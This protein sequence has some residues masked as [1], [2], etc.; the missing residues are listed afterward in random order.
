MRNLLM[1]GPVK[2]F[3]DKTNA[4]F[5]I[6]RRGAGLRPDVSGFTGRMFRDSVAGYR[7]IAVPV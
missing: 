5:Y 6:Q 2:K 4:G 7:G 1:Q 3:L